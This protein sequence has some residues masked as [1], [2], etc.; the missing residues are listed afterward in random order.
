MYISPP[1]TL[2]LHYVEQLAEQH[3]YVV[4]QVLCGVPRRKDTA[5]FSRVDFDVSNVAE[6]HK[7]VAARCPGLLDRL[8]LPPRRVQQRR[9]Q[10][11]QQHIMNI[12]SRSEEHERQETRSVGDETLYGTTQRYQYLP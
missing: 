9:Q 6:G 12:M 7:S 5:K 2:P 10:Q 11:R 4:Y 8:Y 1:G 3:K